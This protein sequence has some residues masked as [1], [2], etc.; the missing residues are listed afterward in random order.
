VS[1]ILHTSAAVNFFIVGKPAQW[2]YR[3]MY[4][5]P[6]VGDRC[7]FNDVRFDVL[8]V[9]WCLDDDATEIGVRVNVELKKVPTRKPTP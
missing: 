4:Q 9:E 6:R 3:R 5:V 7:V 1:E 8:R 2:A